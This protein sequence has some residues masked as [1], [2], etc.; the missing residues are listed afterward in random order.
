MPDTFDLKLV[1]SHVLPEGHW[2]LVTPPTSLT[3]YEDDLTGSAVC[4]AEHGDDGVL[5]VVGELPPHKPV[6]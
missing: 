2:R 5:T 3:W 6:R 4:I 1:P